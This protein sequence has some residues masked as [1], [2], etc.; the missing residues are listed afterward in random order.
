MMKRTERKSV[1]DLASVI[2]C[3]VVGKIFKL[4]F[5]LG[6]TDKGRVVM[7]DAKIN[8]DDN[9]E[10]RQKEVFSLDDKSLTDEKEVKLTQWISYSFSWQ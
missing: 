1:S 9:A 3:I 4:F 8:F 6:L 7:F 10:F 5:V 2:L